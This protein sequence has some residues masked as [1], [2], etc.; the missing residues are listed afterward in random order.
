MG[1]MLTQ[2]HNSTEQ[3]ISTFSQKINDAQ[4]K[5]TIGEQELL[6]AHK[7]CW[8][9]HNIIY[10]CDILIWCDRK[11][12]TNAETKHT[13]L[14]ILC[15]RLTLNSDN[16]AKFE[17][18]AGELNTRADR[19]SP[20]P[21]I[22]DVPPNLTSEIYT[23]NELN[24]NT[25]YN[26]PLAMTL[27]KE[28][29]LKDDKIQDALQKHAT[30]DRFGTME[31]GKTSVHTIDGKIIKPTSLQKCIIE[32]YHNKLCHPGITQTINSISQIFYWKGMRSQV[33]EYVKTFDKCQRH[34]IV[35]KPNYGTLPL[36]PALCNK[37][38][39]E[40]I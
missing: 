15:Q 27:V 23:I 18:L 22:D 26:L 2:E 9:F 21:M 31:F 38:P 11:N 40:K 20:L 13:N 5:Y 10:G 12:I 39:F 36:V 1:A 37:K 16:G 19:L 7:A 34:K 3:V 25:N 17:H 24:D 28:E 8:F 30:N 33:K 4:L 29:Q 35:G 32:W 14:C 6:A